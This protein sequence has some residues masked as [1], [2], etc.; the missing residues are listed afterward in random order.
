MEEFSQ[1]IHTRASYCNCRIRTKVTEPYNKIVSRTQ[2]LRRLQ[3]VAAK[4]YLDFFE[5]HDKIIRKNN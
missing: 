5:Y 1:N 3:V 4:G 2:Q